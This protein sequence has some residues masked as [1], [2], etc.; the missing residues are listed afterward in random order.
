MGARFVLVEFVK[1]TVR[2]GSNVWHHYVCP[3]FQCFFSPGGVN[4]LKGCGGG[5]VN[6]RHEKSKCSHH[7]DGQVQSF[8]EGKE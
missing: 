2:C 6:V 1:G 5:D 7:M 4:G 3:D 8:L